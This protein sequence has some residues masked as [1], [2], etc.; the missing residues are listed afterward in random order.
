MQL[1][2]MELYIKEQRVII[3]KTHYKCVE[4]Y[5]ETVRQVRGIFR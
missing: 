5:A 4:S 1:V 3:L 2:V